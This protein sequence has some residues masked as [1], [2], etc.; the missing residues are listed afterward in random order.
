M[1]MK[2]RW[3][4]DG[5]Y[6]IWHFLFFFF[7]PLQSEDMFLDC[8]WAIIFLPRHSAQGDFPSISAVAQMTQEEVKATLPYWWEKPTEAETQSTSFL[9]L[10]VDKINHM[11]LSVLLSGI[12]FT[13]I[14]F[15]LWIFPMLKKIAI[16]LYFAKCIC[17]LYKELEE[18]ESPWNNPWL[19][20]AVTEESLSIDLD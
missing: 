6:Q 15:F 9:F 2:E 19:T 20:G 12:Q 10:T 1:M 17:L 14:H 4:I 18:P 5:F 13:E 3:E 11:I 8:E 16:L 7:L